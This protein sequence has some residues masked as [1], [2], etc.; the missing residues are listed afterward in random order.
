MIVNQKAL[1]KVD[2][3]SLSKSAS[4]LVNPIERATYIKLPTNVIAEINRTHLAISFNP[5]F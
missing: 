3:S 5:L 4:L 2:I 1:L